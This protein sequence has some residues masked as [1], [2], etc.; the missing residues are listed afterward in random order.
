MQ[1][2]T[3]VTSQLLS[4]LYYACDA[5]LT[6]HLLTQDYR[7][8]ESIHFRCLRLIVKDFRQRIPREWVT[9]AT[10]RLPPR[11]WENFVASSLA[12]KIRQTCVPEKIY[13]NIFKNTYT[14]SRKEGRLF[15]YDSSK[16]VQGR[17]MSKYWIGSILG[18]IKTPRTD[19]NMSNDQICRLLKRTF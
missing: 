17:A 14:L 10:Q 4:I 16:T 1:T 8:L 2:K 7:K 18:T 13:G 15:G 12:I 6:L 19:S 5:Q 3:L 11:Q 9:T